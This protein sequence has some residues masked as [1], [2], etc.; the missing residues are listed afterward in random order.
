MKKGIFATIAVAL[1]AAVAVFLIKEE[2]ANKAIKAKN[3][4]NKSVKQRSEHERNE[5]INT[6]QDIQTNKNDEVK[7][8]EVVQDVEE[9]PEED[10]SFN[11]FI[12]GINEDND[13]DFD[14]VKNNPVEEDT[15]Y[16]KMAPVAEDFNALDQE[17][18][19]PIKPVA[20]NNEY[21]DIFSDD[22]LD[23]ISLDDLNFLNLENQSDAAPV[24]ETETQPV[25]DVVFNE[26]VTEVQKEKTYTSDTVKEIGVIYSNLTPEFIEQVLDKLPNYNE[27]FKDGEASRIVHKVH[28]E[29]S[30]D[31]MKFIEIVKTAGYEIKGTDESGNIF[32]QLDF[33]NH[34]SKILSEIYNV[35]NQAASLNGLYKGNVL[36]KI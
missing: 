16:D 21:I 36:E 17:V 31:L 20:I 2:R 28:F 35:A 23:E 34:D 25:E 32:I 30:A 3:K 13:I 10:T 14:F 29:D 11:E 1:G 19:A 24:E 12:D 4:I 5:L 8:K 15:I 9:F 26:N 6:I 18:V 7:E 22:D 27:E 33:D